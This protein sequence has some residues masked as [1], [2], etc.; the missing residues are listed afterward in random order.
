MAAAVGRHVSCHGTM[1][2]V[3]RPIKGRRQQSG[4]GRLVVSL[5]QVGQAGGVSETV[6]PPASGSVPGRA[7][8]GRE[9]VKGVRAG[10]VEAGERAR[11]RDGTPNWEAGW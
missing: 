1:F 6:V 11:Y 2:K 4:T 8:G 9:W 7:G 10:G 3:F 5:A